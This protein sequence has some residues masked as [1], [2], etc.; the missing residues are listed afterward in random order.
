MLG[1][2]AV[3]EKSNEIPAA[4]ELLQL[5]DLDGTVVTIDALHTQHD[6][7][8]VTGSGGDYVL[9]VKA[10]RD[11]CTRSSRRFPGPRSPPSRG[12]IEDM[13]AASP[14]RSRSLLVPAWVEFGGARQVAQM[15]R[16]VTRKGRKPSRSST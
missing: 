13:D 9:T 2:V 1:Q 5:L 12:R 8:L 4:R 11:R 7:A 16:T 6:T 10:N 3:R 14:A 15:R